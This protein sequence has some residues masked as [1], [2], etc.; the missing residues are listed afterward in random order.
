MRARAWTGRSRDQAARWSALAGSWAQ[1]GRPFN[2][3]YARLREAEAAL[4]Q[5]LPREQVAEALEVARTTARQLGA[6]PL[7]EQID[8]VARRARIRGGSD[9]ARARAGE[10]SGLT[11][12]ELDVLRLLVAGHTNREIGQELYMSPKTASVHVSRILSKLGVKTRTEA[13]GAAYRL[14]LLDSRQSGVSS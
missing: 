8:K 9:D 11:D 14:G 12:R 13:A 1:L 2:S 5:Q 3:T 7:L 4:A 6:A 10:S